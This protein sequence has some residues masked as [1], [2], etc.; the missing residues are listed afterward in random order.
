M[1]TLDAVPSID[2]DTAAAIGDRSVLLDVRENQEW[3]GGHA[4]T[5]VHIPMS[6]LPA[7]V[8][9]LDRTQ[10]IVCVCRSGNRSARV[11][12]WLCAQGFD[13]RNLTGGMQTWSTIGHPMVDH[14]GRPGV[15]V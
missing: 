7:R 10:T 12:A 13:A 2:V 8:D 9:E 11:T 4:P 5:A 1:P 14:A 3:M 6:E 15:V